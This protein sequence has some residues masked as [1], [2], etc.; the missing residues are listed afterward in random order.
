[1]SLSW[2]SWF[3]FGNTILAYPQPVVPIAP[4]FMNCDARYAVGLKPLDCKFAVS[5]MPAAREGAEAEWAVNHR[6]AQYSL[7]MTIYNQRDRKGTCLSS[8]RES[9]RAGT[10]INLRSL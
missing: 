2:P 9:N 7:P 8:R 10:D 1:M 3:T 6:A 5:A 4:D